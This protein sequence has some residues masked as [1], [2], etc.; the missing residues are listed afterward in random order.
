MNQ[1]PVQSGHFQLCLPITAVSPRLMTFGAVLTTSQGDPVSR[2]T[3]AT[4]D[5]V[6]HIW[7]VN[8]HADLVKPVSRRV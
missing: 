8:N 4:C 1:L 5:V 2:K 3:G 6:T 7:Q